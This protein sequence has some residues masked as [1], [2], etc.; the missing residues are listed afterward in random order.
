[1]MSEN[2]QCMIIFG[3]HCARAQM[4]FCLMYKHRKRDT[5]QKLKFK[6]SKLWMEQ[7]SDL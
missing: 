2:F 3:L 7:T 5:E 6:T 4:K 1:M